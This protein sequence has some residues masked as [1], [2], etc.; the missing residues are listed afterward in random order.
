MKV[1]PEFQFDKQTIRQIAIEYDTLAYKTTLVRMLSALYPAE[2][3]PAFSKFELHKQLNDILI[4]HHK[5][6]GEL[7]YTLF[8]EFVKKNIVAAFEIKVN[9][10][11]AD[12]LTVNGVSR[13]FEIKSGLDNLSKL[14]KQSSDY[15][16]VFDYNYVVVDI[17]HLKNSE[18]LIPPN[19]GIWS[20]SNGRKK[21]HRD[22]KPNTE[23]NPEMQLNL[24]SKKELK[25]GFKEEE[26]VK[27]EI[28]KNNSSTEINNRFKKLLK[29]RYAE[30]WNFL[31]S[32]CEA[33]LP[34]DIQ[35][36][37]NTNIEPAVI[38]HH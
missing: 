31:I 38:Y 15:V 24:L 30:R 36:F 7:K 3:L 25:T 20:F 27:L 18:D 6:E 2:I 37:F 14:R 11:R 29:Q 8:K 9:N 34:I 33:I 21:I 19:F 22:A 10:S 23:I 17:K 5:G 13:S 28:L 32:N 16:S 12:F 35:F 26:G 4:K 1:F